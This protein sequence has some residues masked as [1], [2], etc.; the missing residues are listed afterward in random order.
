MKR[1]DVYYDGHVYSVGQ[2]ELEDVQSAIAEGHSAGGTWLLVNDGEGTRR[3]AYLWIAA[4]T[5]IAL[6][7]IQDEP[8]V[9]TADERPLG[10]SEP[11]R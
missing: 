7:P 6:V 10:S 11:E 9:G 4:G 2:R 8:D 3:D 5:S 1:I